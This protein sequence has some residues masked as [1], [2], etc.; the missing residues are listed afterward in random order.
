VTDVVEETVELEFI[1]TDQKKDSRK[2]PP[3]G[4]TIAENVVFDKT[5]RI[6]KRR[7]YGRHEVVED[8]NGIPIQPGNV[9]T[10]VGTRADELVVFGVEWLYA[11]TSRTSAMDNATGLVRRGPIARMN[12]RSQAIAVAPITEN[13]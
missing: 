7:G 8:V 2:L 4:L 10:N 3:G 1:G 6:D 11:V 13:V 12:I 5:G 9:F